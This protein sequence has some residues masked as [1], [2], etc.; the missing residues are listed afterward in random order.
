[1]SKP[2]DEREQDPFH[3]AW[4]ELSTCPLGA[5]GPAHRLDLRRTSPDSVYNP[6]PGSQL[7]LFG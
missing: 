3:P 7:C 4:T 1:M 2:R 6:A 5:L